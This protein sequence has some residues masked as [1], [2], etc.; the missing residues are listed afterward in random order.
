M[1]TFELLCVAQQRQSWAHT[2][3]S[4]QS[5]Q[6]IAACHKTAKYCFESTIRRF[7]SDDELFFAF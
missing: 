6:Q 4:R 3:L 7:D 2:A 1:S 5:D